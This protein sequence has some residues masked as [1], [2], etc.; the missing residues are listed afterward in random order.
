[1]PSLKG[2]STAIKEMATELIESKKLQRTLHLEIEQLRLQLT[3]MQAAQE[4]VEQENQVLR[5][6]SD[7]LKYM[8]S[9]QYKQD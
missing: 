5:S 7:Q 6:H 3:D 2:S 9:Q 1:M 8:N 4:R